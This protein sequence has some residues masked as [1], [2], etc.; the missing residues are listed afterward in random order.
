MAAEH[1]RPGVATGRRPGGPRRRLGQNDL[2]SAAGERIVAE[3]GFAP[4]DLVVEIGAGLGALTHALARRRLETLAFEIDPV[5]VRRLRARLAHAPSVRVVEADFL[6]ARL[7]TRPFRVIGSLPFGRTTDMLH[8]LLDDPALPLLRADVIVQW[9]VAA[10]RAAVPPT[11]LLGA[12]W[13]PWWEF[14]LG[15][16]IAA[17][18]FVPVPRVDA[19]LLTIVRRQPPLL[20]PDLARAFA[21]F[22]RVHW[23]FARGRTMVPPGP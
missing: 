23:P 18:E 22:V 11:T 3:A 14:R 5:R 2:A 9:E 6:R 15:R 12:A 8:R 19:A 21:G 16:R 7:P 17:A 4:A 10:K 20:P 13:A 1:R